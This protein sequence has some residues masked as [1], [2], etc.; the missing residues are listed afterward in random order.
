MIHPKEIRRDSLRTTKNVLES[1][2]QMLSIETNSS[3]EKQSQLSSSK[4]RTSASN[5]HTRD[6]QSFFTQYFN[7]SEMKLRLGFLRRRS[8]ESSIT[9]VRP[10]PHEAQKWATSFADLMASTCKYFL[11]AQPSFVLHNQNRGSIQMSLYIVERP[12]PVD[13]YP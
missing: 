13:G 7:R 8:T 1:L 3:S 6:N 12:Y 5:S 2:N 10:Q 9:T 11:L 4:K